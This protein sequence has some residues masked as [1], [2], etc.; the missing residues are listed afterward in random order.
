MDYK[1][2]K[3]QL[4]NEPQKLRPHVVICGA[5][6]SVA[7]FPNGD[8]NGQEIPVMGNLVELVGLHEVFSKYGISPLEQNFENIYSKIYE[9]EPDTP[10]LTEIDKIV[11]DF[12]SNLCLPDYPTLYDHLILSLRSKDVIATFNWDPFLFDAWERNRYKISVP[13]IVH[14]H[15]NVRIGYCIEHKVHGEINQLCLECNKKLTPSKLLYPISN[16]NYSDD[17]YI[18]SEWEYV[19]DKLA[20]AFTIT[21]FGYSAPNSDKEA[22]ELM[23][24]AWK[25]KSERKLTEIEFIDIKDTEILTEQWKQFRYTHHY[26]HFKNFYESWIP[27]HPRR[28]CEAILAPTFYGKF[29]DEYPLPNEYGFDDLF[30]WIE[31]LIHAEQ[32]LF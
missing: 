19:K 1:V 8:V 22:F 21:I 25:R 5:G 4:I 27:N 6:A 12:F 20:D 7:A 18:K 17:P 24:Q 2:S 13:K 29:V 30:D 10:L 32:S 16:K 31:P 15:G 23:N 28:T 3:E 9:K 11:Y 14:L 26:H